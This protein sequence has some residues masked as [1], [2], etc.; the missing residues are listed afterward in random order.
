MYPHSSRIIS[1]KVR[2]YARPI[3]QGTLVA[4]AVI[5]ALAAG[6]RFLA[7][8]GTQALFGPQVESMPTSGPVG[9]SPFLELRGFEDGERVDVF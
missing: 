4:I 3:A 5:T 7:R 2:R 8:G 9:M 1:G 6:Y